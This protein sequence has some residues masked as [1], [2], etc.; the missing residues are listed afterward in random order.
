[1]VRDEV[2]RGKYSLTFPIVGQRFL[3]IESYFNSEYD[4]LDFY[5]R[6]W[7]ESADKWLRSDPNLAT[8]IRQNP[9]WTPAGTCFYQRVEHA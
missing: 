2:K 9:Y 8:L 4:M 3:S 5:K 7:L 1:M 6:V